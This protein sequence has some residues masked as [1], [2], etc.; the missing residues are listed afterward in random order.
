MIEKGKDIL[1]NSVA[2]FVYEKPIDRADLG[3]IINRWEHLGFLQNLEKKLKPCVATSFEDMSLYILKNIEDI[4]QWFSIFVFPLMYRAIAIYYKRTNKAVT[5]EI[6]KIVEFFKTTT[7][8]DVNEFVKKNSI[9]SKYL[10]N[11]KTDNTVTLFN[12]N[13][14][15]DIDTEAHF[16][17]VISE[18]MINPIFNK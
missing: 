3:K 8:G 15:L 1:K 14:N 17:G 7:I 10:N 4:N 9:T 18:M 5:P 12:F 16:T 2:Q 11:F 6:N 13:E